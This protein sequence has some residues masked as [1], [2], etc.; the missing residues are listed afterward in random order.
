MVLARLM[1]L[2]MDVPC[3]LRQAAPLAIASFTRDLG[4]PDAD[5]IRFTA[6]SP[7]FSRVTVTAALGELGLLMILY[8]HGEIVLLLVILC[9]SFSAAPFCL[10][11]AS[12]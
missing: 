1:R 9:A 3:A 5:A 7:L 11:Y 6:V 8:L 2:K 12:L 4:R 10:D